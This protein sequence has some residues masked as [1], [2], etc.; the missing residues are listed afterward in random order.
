MDRRNFI[1]GSTFT[2][3]LASGAFGWPRGVRARQS[4]VPVVGLLDSA[5]GRGHLAEVGRGL[6]ENGFPEAGDVRFEHSGW[7]GRG[8]SE[9][10][11]AGYAAKLV[12]RQ[13][14]LILAFSGQ[15][16][17][18]AQ[19]VMRTTPIVCLADNYLAMNLM[20]RQS[21]P[22]SNLTGIAIPDAELTA[23][24][25]EI[26]RQLVPTIEL[27]VLVTDPTN[28]LVHEVEV[29]EAQAK[30]GAFGLRFSTIEWA[31][32]GSIEPGLAAL[33]RDAKAALIFGGGLPFLTNDAILAYLAIQYGFP[34]MHGLRAAAEEGGLVSFG[35]R[36]DEAGYLM[37][38]YAARILKG[39]KPANLPIRPMT[40]TELVINRWPAKALG[41]EIPPS[42]LARADE[43]I[44]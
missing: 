25:I 32:E 17:L 40:R 12:E 41:L 44:D 24:R 37:G 33:P 1:A 19:T 6:R 42:L 29:R 20:E 7:S 2:A 9:Q 27:V 8:F 14:A 35:A 39:D 5:W 18:A 3:L 13:V 15:A 38:V 4:K 10:H 16:A 11:L 36:L 43:V 23:K 31:G 28:I 21:Q 26:V 34:A 22:G 30:A